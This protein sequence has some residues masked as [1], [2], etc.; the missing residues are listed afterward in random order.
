MLTNL[1]LKVN[2]YLIHFFF[3]FFAEKMAEKVNEHNVSVWIIIQ[4]SLKKL[5]LTA[6]LQ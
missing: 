4:F 6:T 3:F 1:I 5:S 2:N